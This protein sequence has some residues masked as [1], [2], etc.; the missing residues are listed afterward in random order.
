MWGPYQDIKFCILGKCFQLNKLV[1][2]KF[3]VQILDLK[4]KKETSEFSSTHLPMAL[5]LTYGLGHAASV[6]KHPFFP[7]QAQL[8]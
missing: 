5:V 3:H 4:K 1:P 7:Y 2:V 6:D 8:S